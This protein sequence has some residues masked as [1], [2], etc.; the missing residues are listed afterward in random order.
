MERKEN[1][2][3]KENRNMC[4]CSPLIVRSFLINMLQPLA[5]LLNIELNAIMTKVARI[6]FSILQTVF[7]SPQTTRTKLYSVEFESEMIFG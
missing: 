2:S 7:V 1:L 6:I 4:K 3:E 5:S